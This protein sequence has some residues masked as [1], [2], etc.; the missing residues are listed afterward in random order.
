MRKKPKKR[1]NRYDSAHAVDEDLIIHPC[2]FMCMIEA[3]KNREVAHQTDI[4]ALGR[5]LNLDDAWATLTVIMNGSRKS[6]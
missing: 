3:S 6:V 5:G 1:T 4:A 2:L